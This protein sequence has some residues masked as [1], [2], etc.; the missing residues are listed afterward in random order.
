MESL[1]ASY[2][3]QRQR[4][5]AQSS[6]GIATPERRAAWEEEAR[7]AIAAHDAEAKAEAWDEGAEYMDSDA[8]WHYDGRESNPY[9][10][11]NS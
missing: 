4:A 5:W 9:R 10:E 7:D 11:E 8:F 3:T 2:V 1:I 6:R